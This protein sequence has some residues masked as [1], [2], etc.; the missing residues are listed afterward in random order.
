MSV[1]T[2]QSSPEYVFV[3]IEYD[4]E[5]LSSVVYPLVPP[6][7]FE[8]G[9]DA[10]FSTSNMSKHFPV[11]SRCWGVDCYAKSVRLEDLD[12]THIQT[13]NPTMENN[14]T[15]IPPWALPLDDN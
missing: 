3:T 10:L 12:A 1:T 2:V 13:S 6:F 7:G 11:L 9:C 8:N 14:I 4:S 5:I 15:C